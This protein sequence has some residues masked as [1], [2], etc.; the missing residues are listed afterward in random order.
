MLDKTIYDL[1]VKRILKQNNTHTE[2]KQATEKWLKTLK[3]EK[4]HGLKVTVRLPM[5]Y[6]KKACQLGR[7]S[8]TSREK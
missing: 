4:R 6:F 1:T 5:F 3:R 7:K 2:A 8:V